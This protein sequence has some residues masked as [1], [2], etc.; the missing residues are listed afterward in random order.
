MTTMTLPQHHHRQHVGGWHGVVRLAAVVL[1]LACYALSL[2]LT[3]TM[4]PPAPATSRDAKRARLAADGGD[5]GGDHRAGGAAALRLAGPDG[6]T[7]R[8]HDGI[9]RRRTDI[10]DAVLQRADEA[11]EIA[12]ELQ[13]VV[14]TVD[15]WVPAELRGALFVGHLVTD[16]DSVGGA[17]GAAALYGGRAVRASPVNSETAFAL[18]RWGLEAP[19][20]IEDVL[21]EEPDARICLVDHQQTSQMNPAIDPDRV[22][23]VID[24][25]ALQSKTIVTD[26]PIY[27]DIRPWGSMSTIVGH[28]F[29]SHQ[30]RPSKGVAGVLLCAILSDTLNLQG[31]TTTECESRFVG[32]GARAS[33]AVQV[34][35]CLLAMQPHVDRN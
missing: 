11:H 14:P 12:G 21:K 35:R 7:K 3:G 33:G 4:S 22:V 9:V 29:L 15:R 31:P 8:Y 27:I 25:H 32:C 26:R 24:H 20:A 30:R 16:L 6:H 10:E 13:E 18:D 5:G 28:T 17:I 23:G 34:Q 1:P 2:F 19:P